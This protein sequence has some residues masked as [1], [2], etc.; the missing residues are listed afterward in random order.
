MSVGRTGGLSSG[1]DHS[2]A[3]WSKSFTYARSERSNKEFFA[4]LARLGCWPATSPI[5]RSA[6]ALIQNSVAA[7]ACSLTL[8]RLETPIDQ[9]LMNAGPQRLPSQVGN[10]A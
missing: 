3:A 6:S 1:T 8:D 7:I 4:T 9:W 2:R 5:T 10:R